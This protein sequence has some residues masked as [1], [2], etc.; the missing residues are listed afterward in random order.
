[1]AEFNELRA[2][3]AALEF[4]VKC[5]NNGGRP[6]ETPRQVLEKRLRRKR[7]EFK[8]LITNFDDNYSN[9]SR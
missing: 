8:R 5:I 7:S 1:M 2:Q 4:A 6:T 3:L 9:Q